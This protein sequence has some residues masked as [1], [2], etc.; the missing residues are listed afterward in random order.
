MVST[1]HKKL[2]RDLHS[3][4]GPVISIS[5]VVTCGVAAFVALQGTWDSLLRSRDHYYAR[6]RFGDVFAHLERAPNALAAR[7]ATLP[8]VA[9]S[10]TRIVE[11]AR[12]PIEGL[13]EP[14]LADVV[15][16]PEDGR[17]PLSRV[18][19]VAGRLPDPMRSR[20]VL[21]LEAFAQ[22]HAVQPGDTLKVTLAGKRQSLTVVG[23][24]MSPEYVFAVSPGAIAPS[25]DKFA[26]L[27]MPRPAVEA[28][29]GRSGSFNSVVLRLQPTASQ[30][31]TIAA[32]DQLLEPYGA[33]GAHG[34]D[35]Q[36]SNMFLSQELMQLQS[37]ASFAPVI[38]LGVAAFLL[39]VVLS[40][41][42]QLQ[43]PQIATL[44]AVG[45]SNGQVARHYLSLALLI[46]MLG[47][48]AGLGLGAWLG[49]LMTDLYTEFFRL[50][51]LAFKL[52][53]QVALST[54][55]ASFSSAL[56]GSWL[57][58]RAVAR[59]APAEAM[60]PA[61]P[62][63]YRRGVGARLL[64]PLVGPAVRM[65]WR[66]LTRRPARLA[67]SVI[68]ISLGVAILVLGRSFN[69]AM[70]LLTD[71]YLQTAQREDLAVSFSREIDASSRRVF[72]TLPGVRRVEWVGSRAV[73]FVHGSYRKNSLLLAHEGDATL[74]PLL[75]DHLRIV[76]VPDD[77]VILTKMLSDILHA[78]V[79]SRI[80]V[81]PL[82]G[83]R[84]P[85]EVTVTGTLRELFGLQG[86]MRAERM[87]ALLGTA[88]AASMALLR[89][90]PSRMSRVEQ[91]LTEFPAV[92][93]VS[94][95]QA[96][97]DQFRDQSGD[98]VLVFALIL[99]IFAVVIAAGVVYNNARV[100]L[101]ARERDLASL[102]VL[103]FTQAEVA[104]IL[105]GELTVQV[106]LAI[107]VGL[108]LGR[109]FSE[110]MMANTDPEMYRL[111]AMVSLQT[112]AF[113]TLVIL[114]AAAATAFVIHRKLHRL[115]LIAVL[116]TRE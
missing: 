33:F 111:P 81:R 91:E 56:L 34:R 110:A 99:T 60:R 89:V 65:V 25:P 21:L 107:P 106:L 84:R 26:V 49:R 66:E 37:M 59:L 41:L 71:D 80:H 39:N 73:E 31:A 10:Y 114:G 64:G 17:P 103:G 43:R 87:H 29:F 30:D 112:Y 28:A 76:D 58:V 77:G 16:L 4:R 54:L 22:E 36:L 72:E 67:M 115:D 92:L 1:L 85:R 12:L 38:F 90:D 53:A 13:T 63:R 116:K 101:S 20:E 88:P 61:A 113:A 47:T 70:S 105:I 98:S 62:P 40:R 102:R 97:I 46:V 51:T 5:L 2:L 3:L 15:S 82:T 75:D 42:V 48:S 68:G 19:L 96:A 6:E 86:H 14:A 57:S 79:G 52:G 44:K 55:V 27:W 50:P 108:W 24:A 11:Q 100:T 93:G 35:R 32:L 95:K 69:D 7:L 109:V 9:T 18:R 45:Y 74:R 83:D 78:P 23:L 94:R 8:G 104:Q